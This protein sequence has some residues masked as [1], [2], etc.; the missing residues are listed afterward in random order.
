MKLLFVTCICVVFFLPG[1]SAYAQE[2]AIPAL[3]EQREAVVELDKQVLSQQKVGQRER[4]CG[5]R[6]C[7]FLKSQLQR[8]PIRSFGQ[9]LFR[10]D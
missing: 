4:V 2:Q 10:R 5:S 6:G 7:G 1:P 3:P 9:R 8:K